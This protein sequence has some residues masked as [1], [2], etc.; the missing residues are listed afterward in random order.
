MRSVRAL[1]T[2]PV[3]IDT[4]LK[5][6]RERCWEHLGLHLPHAHRHF[7]CKRGPRFWVPL[8]LLLVSYIIL[9]KY[10]IDVGFRDRRGQQWSDSAQGLPVRVQAQGAVVH[11]CS[12]SSL[13]VS[14]AGCHKQDIQI[15]RGERACV[16]MVTAML[17]ALF[18]WRHERHKRG[19]DCLLCNLD[20]VHGRKTMPIAYFMPG[21]IPL[22]PGRRPQSERHNPEALRFP[23]MP[24]LPTGTSHLP[25]DDAHY[26]HMQR[27]LHATYSSIAPKRRYINPS[28][29]GPDSP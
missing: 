15:F 3:P 2:L 13:F 8:L 9:Q 7:R 24:P 27:A 25:T 20:A 21:C 5:V 11:C 18:F 23:T 6:L 26:N 10:I 22:H 4:Y 14:L 29:T 17:Q 12:R 1:S 19:K 16:T 28:C